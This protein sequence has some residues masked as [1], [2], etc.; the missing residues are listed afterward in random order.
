M[1]LRNFSITK[2]DSVQHCMYGI[3]IYLLKQLIIHKI[4]CT[5]IHGFKKRIVMSGRMYVS[6]KNKYNRFWEETWGG[7]DGSGRCQ[8]IGGGGMEGKSSEKDRWNLGGDVE[9]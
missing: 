1:K 2:N 8:V 5:D 6:G 4:Q 7:W 3:T 9:T